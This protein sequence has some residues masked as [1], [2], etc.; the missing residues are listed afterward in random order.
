VLPDLPRE[1]PERPVDGAHEPARLPPGPEP[2][3]GFEQVADAAHRVEGGPA[4]PLAG[5]ARQGHEVVPAMDDA[6]RT[7][8]G[9]GE[10]VAEAGR[11]HGV[12]HP[13]VD[14]S[15][16]TPLEGTPLLEEAVESGSPHGIADE[17]PRVHPRPAPSQVGPAGSG[18]ARGGP[19]PRGVNRS[20]GRRPL[21]PRRALR[22]GRSGASSRG[23]HPRGRSSVGSRCSAAPTLSRSAE[24]R[25]PSG[26]SASADT[27]RP[28]LP[29]S[30]STRPSTPPR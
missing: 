27:P 7:E 12:G 29:R 28:V 9:L 17:L 30:G 2:P 26:S 22:W 5:R 23:H 15:G 10:H 13:F 16:A 11:P 18:S 3:F 14:R 19:A 21:H 6:R 20:T 4:V 1:G 24:A 25:T 8:A